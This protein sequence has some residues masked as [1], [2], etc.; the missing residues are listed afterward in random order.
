MEVIKQSHGTSEIDVD[1]YSVG[2]GDG[3]DVFDLLRSAL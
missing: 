1:F 3:C 2:D